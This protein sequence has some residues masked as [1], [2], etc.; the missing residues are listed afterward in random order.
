MDLLGFLQDRS[1]SNGYVYAGDVE[2]PVVAQSMKL[3]ISEVIQYMPL[4][5]T[6]HQSTSEED[7]RLC[8]LRK[9]W[10]SPY[11]ASS[12]GRQSSSTAFS[13][14]SLISDPSGRHHSLLVRIIHT[15]IIFSG[16]GPTAL[17]RIYVS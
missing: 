14:H 8:Q 9:Q 10:D 1:F 4:R 3:D 16:N 6:G 5:V 7:Q 17:T 2:N 15:Q 11:S 12:E 13:S